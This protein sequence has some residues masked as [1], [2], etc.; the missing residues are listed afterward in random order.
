MMKQRCAL[1]CSLLLLACFGAQG[2]NAAKPHRTAKGLPRYMTDI[3]QPIPDELRLSDA[4]KTVR[5]VKCYASFA[6]T[7]T[8][9]EVVRKC[10]IPDEHQGSGIYIFLYDMS[11]GSVVAIGTSDLKHLMYVNHIQTRGSRSLLHGGPEDNFSITLERIGCLGSCPDYKITI[12]GNGTVQY[13]GHAYVS[14]EGIRNTTIP[15]LAVQKLQ[16]NLRD[17]DF[18][19]WPEQEEV[20]VDFPE[21]NITATLDGQSKHVLE[22]CNQPG[23]VLRLASEIDRTSGSERWIGKHR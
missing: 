9:Q 15:V 14:V 21:I 1:V 11:D 3:P 18:L 6:T 22:G 19:H 17:E 7:S 12:Q 10:G 20:C 8:M 5:D 16:Q 13:E 23:R 4:P 2:Q